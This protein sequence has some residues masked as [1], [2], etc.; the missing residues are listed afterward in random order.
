MTKRPSERE[1]F[2]KWARRSGFDLCRMIEQ[3][4]YWSSHTDDAW[5]AWQAAKRDA[6]REGKKK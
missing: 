2:E 6:K 5:L 1:R 3:K 4:T